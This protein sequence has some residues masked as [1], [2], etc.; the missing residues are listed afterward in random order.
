MRAFRFS[1]ALALSIFVA[2]PSS[3]SS[4][5]AA[6]SCTSA[7]SVSAAVDSAINYNK[8]KIEKGVDLYDSPGV[9]AVESPE[10]S[11]DLDLMIEIG[12]RFSEKL[13]PT[14]VAI[15]DMK[16]G[17]VTFL[18]RNLLNIFVKAAFIENAP[19]GAF[20]AKGDIVACQLNWRPFSITRSLINLWREGEW[21][22]IG[23][24][25]VLSFY[26]EGKL[27]KAL[28]AKAFNLKPGTFLEH[29][30]VSPDGNYLTFYTQGEVATQGIYVY[31]FKSERTTYLG[32]FAD[33]HPTYDDTGN[34]IFFHEQGKMNGSDEEIARIGYYQLSYGPSGEVTSTRTILGDPTHPLGTNFVYQKH[35]AYHSGLNLVFFHMRDGLDGKKRIGAIWLDHPDWDPVT[36]KLEDEG[37]KIKKA[38]HMNTSAS[39]PKS[40]L[41][42]VAH[43]EDGKDAQL[44]SLS[45]KQL[46]NIQEEFKAPKGPKNSK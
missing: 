41:F 34:R 45:Y 7:A 9:H 44:M 15:R 27:I 29:P 42:F 3:I 38:E 26:H 8:V 40:P 36:V 33:K 35:P 24:H 31:D 25:S 5:W 12:N 1:A 17:K 20:F 46:K 6:N 43:T 23:Y 18:K 4:A 37:L 10:V 21:A 11:D 2:V 14:D 30:R 16:T 39:D 13:P 28:D 22:P 19:A 32:N